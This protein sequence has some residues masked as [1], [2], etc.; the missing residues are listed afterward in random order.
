MQG[1]SLDGCAEYFTTMNSFR[2]INANIFR[3]DCEFHKG[4]IAITDGLFVDE[5]DENAQIIDAENLYVIPGLV[6]IHFH[7]CKGH[8]FCEGTQEAFRAIR[9]YEASVGVTAICPA[10]MT[11]PEEK[12]LA[13]M[14][15]IRNFHDLAGIYL[16]GPFISPSK[17]GAQNPLYVH[18]PD[19]DM[20]KRLQRDSGGLIRI[21]AIAPEVEGAREFITEAKNIT[22]LSLAHTAC[23]Y[24]TANEAFNMGVSQV[25]H[26]YNAMPPINHRE[27]GP[28]IAA[29]ENKSVNVELI[30]DGIHVH[31]AIVRNTIKA[32]GP[33]RVIFISDSMEAAGMPDGK[34]KLGGLDVIKRGN[35]ATLLDGVTIAGSVTNLLDCMKTAIKNMNVPLEVAVKCSTLNPA[36]AI[37][38]E[39]LYG[40][41]QTGRRADLIALD[42]ELN[43]IWVM[44]NSVKLL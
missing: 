15:E 13:I 23:N 1:Y 20:L 30:C 29:L 44:N 31:P 9:D 19:I 33:D 38:Q 8:D 4:D 36:K 42:K 5:V 25:T 17:V 27:P 3:P 37:G 7:G 11:L 16:E 2:I 22:R 32:F 43:T 41:I 24:D 40:V 18:M 35:K 21:T 26:L 28:I 6:D 39:N 34:Y 12:L 10:T 14:N